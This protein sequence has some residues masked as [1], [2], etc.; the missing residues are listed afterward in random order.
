MANTQGVMAKIMIRP[1]FQIDRRDKR[2]A[3]PHE[4]TITNEFIRVV[5]RRIADGAMPHVPGC[6]IIAGSGLCYPVCPRDDG[7]VMHMC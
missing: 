3:L 1:K 5:M 2:D 4:R 6:E 7:G